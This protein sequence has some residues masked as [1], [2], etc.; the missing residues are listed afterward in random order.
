MLRLVLTAVG[1]GVLAAGNALAARAAPPPP[2]PAAPPSPKAAPSPKNAQDFLADVMTAGGVQVHYLRERDRGG[3]YVHSITKY[4]YDTPKQDGV[5]GA[6]CESRFDAKDKYAASDN[7]QVSLS[8]GRVAGVDHFYDDATKPG[9]RV[10]NGVSVTNNPDAVGV[11]II[12]G[13]MELEQRVMKA[14]QV[15]REA[16][17][18]T[19]SSYGF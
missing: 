1:V 9:V 12:V 19:K 3:G 16:C 8:W 15:L 18:A 6:P 4:S 17:G 11:L 10:M 13:S 5:N 2:A 7:Y 14:M